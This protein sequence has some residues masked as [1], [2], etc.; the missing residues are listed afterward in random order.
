MLTCA[1]PIDMTACKLMEES[2]IMGPL[3]HRSICP[4]QLKYLIKTFWLQASVLYEQLLSSVPY[5]A[6]CPTCNGLFML[7]VC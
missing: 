7:F 4:S 1:C 3:S 5:T 2:A 6:L